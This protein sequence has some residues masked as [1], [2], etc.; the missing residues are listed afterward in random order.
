[1]EKIALGKVGKPRTRPFL[2]IRDFMKNRDDARLKHFQNG[3]C[4]KGHVAIAPL[5]PM[6]ITSNPAEG[7]EL[8]FTCW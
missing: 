1:M 7:G 2:K 6:G 8:I 5:P 4:Q 3:Q